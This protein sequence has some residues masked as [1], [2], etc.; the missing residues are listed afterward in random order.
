MSEKERFAAMAE[1]VKEYES[2]EAQKIGRA[3]V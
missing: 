1:I 3:H 2:L